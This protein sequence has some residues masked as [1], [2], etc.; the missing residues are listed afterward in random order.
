MVKASIFRSDEK[1]AFAIAIEIDGGRAGA[2]AGDLPFGEVADL[3]EDGLPFELAFVLV[4]FGIDGI[5]EE[6]E[7]A[8]VIPIDQINFTTSAFACVLGVEGEEASG[9]GD[10][11][12]FPREE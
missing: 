12:P 6:V 3:S 2:V 1:F 10:E 4:E 7:V 11:D 9:L 5:D 8:V